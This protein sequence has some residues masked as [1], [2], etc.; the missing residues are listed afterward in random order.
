MTS[1]RIRDIRLQRGW[2]LAEAAALA[3]ISISMLSRLERGERRLTPAG[4]VE[5]ARRL[6]IPVDEAFDLPPLGES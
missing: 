2:T 6:G 1:P 4:M 3:G 5:L